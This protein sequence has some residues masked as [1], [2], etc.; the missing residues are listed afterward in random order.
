ME[1]LNYWEN[2]IRQSGIYREF[3][4]KMPAPLNNVYFELLVLIVLVLVGIVKTVDIVRMRMRHRKL[5]RRQEEAR[6]QN[7]ANRLLREEEAR[8]QQGKLAAFFQYLQMQ[9]TH[10]DA[11]GDMPQRQKELGGKRFRIGSTHSANDFEILME[12]AKKNDDE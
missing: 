10:K 4:G 7:E 3:L 12:E 1:Y 5:K 2:I 8:V 6:A 9:G 11:Q